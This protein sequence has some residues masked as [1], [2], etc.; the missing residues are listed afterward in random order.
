[1]LEV[2]GV[3]RVVGDLKVFDRRLPLAT[4][5]DNVDVGVKVAVAED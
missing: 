2:V 4:H 1:M 3:R 5:V